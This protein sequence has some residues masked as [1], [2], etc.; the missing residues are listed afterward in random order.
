[1]FLVS[2][3]N[4]FINSLSGTQDWI[5]A[6]FWLLFSFEIMSVERSVNARFEF[7]LKYIATK[8]EG[9]SEKTFMVVFLLF[10]CAEVN[11]GNLQAMTSIL[12][13]PRPHGNS[14][15]F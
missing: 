7:C 8:P 4:A 5:R 1:M 2:W 14:F 3:N 11:E 12:T 10:S 13:S 9:G 6:F 15:F